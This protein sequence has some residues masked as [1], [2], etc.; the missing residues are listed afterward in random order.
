MKAGIHGSSCSAAPA[1]RRG[2]HRYSVI[3]IL[4]HMFSPSAQ[5]AE[6]YH[7]QS[8]RRSNDTAWARRTKGQSAS[9]KIKVLLVKRW[10]LMSGQ[11]AIKDCHG[12]LLSLFMSIHQGSGKIYNPV[13]VE[14]P[15]HIVRLIP[16][17]R[18]PV[19]AEAFPHLV[20]LSLAISAVGFRG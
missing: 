10:L 12:E 11:G 6:P 7:F 15:A 13:A 2:R 5:T 8:D 4:P 16:R 9:R 3:I 18:L 19:A 14:I 20:D 17:I 1:K